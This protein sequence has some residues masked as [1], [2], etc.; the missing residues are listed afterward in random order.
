VPDGD[1]DP[2]ALKKAVARITNRTPEE[3][4]AARQEI[5]KTL[6]PPMPLPA[7][8]TAQDVWNNLTGKDQDDEKDPDALRRAIAKITNRTPEQKLAAQER[9]IREYKPKRELPPGVSPLEVMP[10]IR[11]AETDEQVI[12]A[13][14][15]LS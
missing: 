4:E 3:R 15:E 10:V 14:K 11:G 13:L 1:H 8:M 7:G 6:P 2:D 5:L 12:A 9:A